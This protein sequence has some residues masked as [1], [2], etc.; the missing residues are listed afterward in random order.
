MGRKNHSKRSPKSLDLLNAAASAGWVSDYPALT[1]AQ[2][3]VLRDCIGGEISAEAASQLEHGMRF[4]FRWS[5]ALQV[6][7]ARL[8]QE[9]AASHSRTPRANLE[10][11]LRDEVRALQ[12]AAGRAS[13]SFTG[14][15]MTT[16]RAADHALDDERRRRFWPPLR[17]GEG[18][19]VL[20]RRL[21]D[22][23]SDIDL[24]LS[25]VDVSVP[26]GR[27][28]EATR[29]TI[30]ALARLYQEVS[31]RIPKR[32]FTI[33]ESGEFL[34]LVRTF[35]RFVR[36]ALPPEARSRLGTSLSKVVREVLA[37]LCSEF[38]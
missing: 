36:S 27:H 31:G 11:Q 3:K 15:S 25:E 37:E 1:S 28:D 23:L 19:E 2:M 17:E 8:G 33:E 9:A 26:L 16:I 13:K 21:S 6:T 35:T 24:A 5:Q 14:V 12:K 18:M 32:A 20:L 30:K 7:W 22:A 4:L 10:T 29:A 38:A 34:E